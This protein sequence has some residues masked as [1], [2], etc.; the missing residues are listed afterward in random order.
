M[1]DPAEPVDPVPPPDTPDQTTPPPDGTPS[2]DDSPNGC[3]ILLG[4]L[5]TALAI[6]AEEILRR[7]SR[8]G[9]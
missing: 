8:P 3:M 6:L 7:L 1:S 5:G 2:K 9:S 4:L